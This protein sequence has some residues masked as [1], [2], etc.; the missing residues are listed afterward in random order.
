MP[1]N[2]YDYRLL[3]VIG[4]KIYS[5]QAED[6]LLEMLNSAGT[7][8]TLR[9]EEIP[10][11]EAS[12]AED[13]SLIHVAHFHKEVFSTFGVPFLLKIKN[14]ENFA[15]VKDRIQKKLEVPEKEFEKV[16]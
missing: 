10:K 8:K 9:I 5:I 14:N 3:E 1:F 13:E 6:T 11:E 16:K 7:T 15:T 2:D 12:L 4:C